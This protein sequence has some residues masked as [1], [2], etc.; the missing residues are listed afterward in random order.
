MKT[1]IMI[2]H[3][4]PPEGHAGVY[5]PLRFV[6]HL[7]K[8][9]WCAK[10]ITRGG[11]GYERYDP[12]LLSLVPGDT[13]V[14]RVREYDPWQAIQMWRAERLQE[15]L[16][17]ASMGNVEKLDA[18]YYAPVRSYIRELVRTIEAWCY[19]PDRAM[20]WIRPAMRATVRLC[21]RER[22]DVIWATA[23]PW[24]SFLVAQQTSQ[25]T[26]LPYVLD[27]RD[28]WT[29][30]ENEFEARRPAWAQSRDRRTLYQLLQGAQ[31]V[32]FR[33]NTEAECYW[34]AYVGALDAARVH[35]IPNGYEGTIEKFTAP[36]GDK[37][38]ILYAGTLSSYRYDTLLQALQGLK[39]AEPTR[40][41]QLRLLF[42]GEGVEELAASAK[43]LDLDDMVA[44]SGPTSYADIARLQQETHALLVLGRPPIMK[45]Y[46]LFASAKL[47]GYLK[48]GK[49]ILGV[50]PPDEAK[51]ILQ[52][53]G[54]STVA[55]AD[56]SAEIIAVLQQL[57]D[58]WSAQTLAS[59]V[60]DRTAC[61]AYSAE[62]QT[63]ALVRALEGLPAMD[64]FVPGTVDIPPSLRRE[65]GTGGWVRKGRR[66]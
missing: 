56:S 55:D 50:L 26:G 57:L 58:A 43:A 22:P 38:Q 28:A 13:E 34:R 54:V 16:S 24:S 20:G 5:R 33:Y 1:V 23:M 53:V 47:F 6:R 61:E 10:V 49:P 30:T 66:S 27:F 17:K 46:E 12:G 65:I 63:A 60:P 31:A 40:S 3:G 19:H 18:A 36:D 44:T 51:K 41:K 39:R 15:K 32:I 21:A 2:A 4:F 9:G 29:V 62:R 37:C 25:R 45:G 8:T 59:L 14:V 52:S 35:I 7:A 11:D 42:V 48:A 64:P